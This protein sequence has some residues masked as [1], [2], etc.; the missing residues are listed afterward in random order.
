MKAIPKSY[1]DST[2]GNQSTWMRV[3]YGAVF[4][5]AVL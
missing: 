3:L 2:G 1:V 5:T 4:V